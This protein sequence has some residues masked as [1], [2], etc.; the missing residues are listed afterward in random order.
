MPRTNIFVLTRVVM[1][2]LKVQGM[3]KL[4]PLVHCTDYKDDGST[5]DTR[6]GGTISTKWV[7]LAE[8]AKCKAKIL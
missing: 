8:Y 5:C 4:R 7:S 2:Y 1:G 3:R 6:F